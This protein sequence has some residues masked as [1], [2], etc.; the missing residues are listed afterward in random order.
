M[1]T[2]Y[3]KGK[4]DVAVSGIPVAYLNDNMDEIE[5]PRFNARLIELMALN[6]PKIYPKYVTM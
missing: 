5:T 6:A 4:T 1:A 2:I 3:S